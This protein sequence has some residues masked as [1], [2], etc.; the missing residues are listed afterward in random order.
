[1]KQ[2][3]NKLDLGL[4]LLLASVCIMFQFGSDI[5]TPSLPAISLYFHINSTW[6]QYTVALYI[7]GLSLFQFVFGPLSDVYGRKPM[8]LI[9]LVIFLLGK[10]VMRY[11]C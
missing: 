8:L 2:T 1:M 6:A 11:G 5:L 9:G 7:L 10:F 3:Q 4:M